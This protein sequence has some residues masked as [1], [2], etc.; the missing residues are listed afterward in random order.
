MTG[1][2]TMPQAESVKRPPAAGAFMSATRNSLRGLDLAAR[3]ERAVR[4]ELFAIAV[5]LPAAFLLSD[6]LWTRI[7]LVAV[8]LLVL[9]LELLNTALETLCD[10]VTP[11]HHP[12]IGAAKDLGSAAV[13]CGLVLALV[14]WGA[15]IGEAWL[16]RGA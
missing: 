9:A 15:A 14:V 3:S 6:H 4:Q 12:A 5:G 2:R 8:L 1:N 16:G 10:H 7:A 11:G 13:F